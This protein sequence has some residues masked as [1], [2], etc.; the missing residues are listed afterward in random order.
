MGFHTPNLTKQVLERVQEYTE[1]YDWYDSSYGNDL[2]DSIELELSEDN[3]IKIMLPNS[4]IDDE[5]SELFVEFFILDNNQ[6]TLFM[7]SDFNKVIDYITNQML[8]DYASNLIDKL[9]DKYGY[10][11]MSLDEFQVQY[12]FDTKETIHIN[13]LLKL[14]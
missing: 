7:S 4:F 10:N 14:F 8:H 9:C 1:N 2:C 5:D 3:F 11:P 12:E 13:N 6:D